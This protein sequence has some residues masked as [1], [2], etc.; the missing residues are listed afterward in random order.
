MVEAIAIGVGVFV[1]I[2]V[3]GLRVIRVI[4]QRRADEADRLA[5]LERAQEYSGPMLNRWGR[6]I[7]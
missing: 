1:A 5:A 4:E 6:E 3:A 2:V 7:G